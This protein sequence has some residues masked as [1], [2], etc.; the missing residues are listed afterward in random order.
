MIKR[1][2]ELIRFLI[3]YWLDNPL[4]PYLRA[5][6]VTYIE[7]EDIITIKLYMT[8]SDVDIYTIGFDDD[9][10]FLHKNNM[11]SEYNNLISLLAT[12]IKF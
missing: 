9:Y 8:T 5:Y 2:L 6:T 11:K 7:K 3:E 12:F 1:H 4:K 10:Y